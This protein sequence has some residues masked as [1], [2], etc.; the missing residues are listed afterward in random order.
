[1]TH[2]F[3]V[4]AYYDKMTNKGDIKR[5]KEAFLVN[6]MSFTEAEARFI[7]YISPFIQGEFDITHI[8][9][10]HL[11]ELFTPEEGEHY[12]RCKIGLISLDEKSGDEK[13][14]TSNIMVLARNLDRAKELLHEGM[15]GTM[16]DYV[17]ESIVKTKIVDVINE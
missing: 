1:M 10:A 6:A 5:V 13:M 14:T 8:I 17:V 11:S 16:A 9:K 7:K 3:E 4:R 15:K 12:F 2:Y